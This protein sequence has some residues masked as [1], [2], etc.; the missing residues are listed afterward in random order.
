V[1]DAVSKAVQRHLASIVGAVDKW[2][3]HS[4]VE[5]REEISVVVVVTDSVVAVVM[6]FVVVAV[7][8]SVAVAHLTTTKEMDTYDLHM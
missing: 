3:D 7:E 1:V 8:D 2:A 5:R 4:S 6:D